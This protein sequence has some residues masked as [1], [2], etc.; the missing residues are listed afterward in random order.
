MPLRQTG[1][2]FGVS[3]T[4]HD[5]GH[6]RGHGM[7]HRQRQIRLIN[8]ALANSSNR[9][10]FTIRGT[11]AGPSTNSAPTV[12]TEI[13]NQTAMSGTVFSYQVELRPPRSRMRTATR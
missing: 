8:Q 5:G 13:P 3:V 6:R 12:A 9:I 7:E 11:A 1:S 2:G 4:K 10:I